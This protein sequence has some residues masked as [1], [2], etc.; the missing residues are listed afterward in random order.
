MAIQ[1]SGCLRPQ[2]SQQEIDAHQ[3][4]CAVLINTATNVNVDQTSR[5]IAYDGA[6]SLGCIG[7]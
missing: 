4:R 3:Q 2:P 5:L 6:K 7:G 1:Q